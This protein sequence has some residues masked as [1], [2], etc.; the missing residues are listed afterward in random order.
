LPGL[1]NP[2]SQAITG[3][4]TL[5]LKASEDTLQE[6]IHPL[7]HILPFVGQERRLSQ[8]GTS[9]ARMP[10]ADMYWSDQARRLFQLDEQLHPTF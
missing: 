1:I 5:K 6:Q 4:P 8:P 7:H 10:S 3:A 9:D 2:F